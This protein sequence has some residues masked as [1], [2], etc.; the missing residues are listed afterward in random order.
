MMV[1]WAVEADTNTAVVLDELRTL[2]LKQRK[3]DPRI[4]QYVKDMYKSWR[5]GTKIERLATLGWQEYESIC[6][7]CE[8]LDQLPQLRIQY[9]TEVITNRSLPVMRDEDVEKYEAVSKKERKK[10]EKL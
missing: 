10:V 6:L 5:K 4:E 7:F 3:K 1:K 2:P 8:M 9:M